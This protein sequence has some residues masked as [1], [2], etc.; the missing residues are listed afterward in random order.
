MHHN[1]F[2]FFSYHHHHCYKAMSTKTITR[3]PIVQSLCN[4]N[5]RQY[6]INYKMIDVY[7]KQCMYWN[8]IQFFKNINGENQLYT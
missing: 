8:W 5:T 7:K 2:V 6:Q 3:K 4:Y 1:L